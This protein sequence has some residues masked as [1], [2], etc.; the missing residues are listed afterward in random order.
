[1][2]VFLLGLLWAALSFGQF[3]PGRYI[4]ELDGPLAA[5]SEKPD[6]GRVRVLAAQAPVRAQLAA[7]G[8]TIH[9]SLGAVVNAVI[10]DIPEDQMDVVA[11]LP[12]VKRITQVRRMKAYM[13]AVPNLLSAPTA[14]RNYGGQE[15]AGLGIKIGIIDTGIDQSHPAFQDSSLKPP[16]GFPRSDT[17]ANLSFTNSKVIV[18]RSYA[19]FYSVPSSADISPRDI[20]GHGT[21]VAMTAAGVIHTAPVGTVSGIA[22]KAF[23]GNYRAC[24]PSDC[25]FFDS[26]AIFK[27]F[28]DAV[29]DGMDVINLSLGSVLAS[30]P[31]DDPFTDMVN[32]AVGRGVIVVAAAGN[33]G[34]DGTTIGDTAQS[35]LVIAAG[36][37]SNARA[38]VSSVIIPDGPKY[39][40]LLASNV[41]DTTPDL[42]G[43]IMD[44]ASLDATGLACNSLSGSAAG[45]IVLILRG[46]CTFEDKLLNA[47]AAGAMGAVVYTDSSRPDALIMGVG[48]ARIPAL[49]I[50]YADGVKLKSFLA[51]RTVAGTMRFIPSAIPTD[52]YRLASFSSIGPSTNYDIKPD[53]VTVGMNVYTAKPGGGYTTVN[54]TSFASPITAGAA[55]FLKGAR[56]G[57]TVPQYRS[58]LIN[59][60]YWMD[61]RLQQRG[62]GALNLDAA[63]NSTIAAFPTS[64]SFGIS[65][66]NADSPRQLTVTNL[67]QSS[68]TFVA[69]VFPL[70]AGP[71]PAIQSE[72]QF[73]LEPGQSKTLNLRFTAN[74]LPGGERNGLFIVRAANSGAQIYVPYWHGVPDNVPVSVSILYNPDTGRPNTSQ[75][76]YFRLLDSAGMPAIGPV[77][78]VITASGGGSVQS[79]SNLNLAS[80][81]VWRA[82]MRMST[83]TGNNTFTIRSGAVESAFTIVSTNTP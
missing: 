11:G 47:A 46:T 70:S 49:S 80:P 75:S 15:K 69:T 17:S 20:E 78:D 72:T 6:D 28:D 4:V 40:A 19:S 58:L 10:A 25:G 30:R 68:D 56:P 41:T 57:L 44:V 73:A 81:G 65:G 33:E 2:R 79:V 55:A 9:D 36:A 37:T 53:L 27:A 60:A 35:Q 12:G 23:L 64:V 39:S 83:T 26:D 50:S 13:D 18:A 22:P 74:G 32:N 7:A 76:V 3:V 48:T 42:N 14:W 52:P 71:A 45:R 77:P 59:S 66:V 63:G 82:T 31:Q 61:G 54:G 51:D 29:A 38:L 5:T 1:M 34:P 24:D 62:N 16:T 43:T 8:A 21:A 67:G